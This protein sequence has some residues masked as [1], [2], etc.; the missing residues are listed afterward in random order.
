VSPMRD[1]IRAA[2]ATLWLYARF[3][4]PNGRPPRRSFLGDS[5]AEHSS[6][7]FAGGG[8]TVTGVLGLTSKFLAHEGNGLGDLVTQ[9]LFGA[10]LTALGVEI[11]DDIIFDLGQFLKPLTA[12]VDGFAGLIGASWPTEILNA[13]Q[14]TTANNLGQFGFAAWPV[15][16]GVGMAGLLLMMYVL[17]STNFSPIDTIYRRN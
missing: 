9:Y 8:L 3:V 12:F 17:R 10:P 15:A 11:V 2:V 13:G 6:I 1:R 16:V 14:T 4:L 5:R 7:K